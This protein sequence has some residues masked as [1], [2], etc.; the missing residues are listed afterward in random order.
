MEN[1]QKESINTKIWLE[2]SEADNPFAAKAA[3][4]HGY[5][6]Y[7]EMLGKATWADMIYLL[8]RGEPPTQQKAALLDALAVALANPGPRDQSVHAAMC[9]GVAGSTAAACLTAA[10]AVGAGHLSGAHEIVLAVEAWDL[11]G[12]DLEKWKAHIR[13]R[14]DETIS[15]WPAPQHPSGFDPHG[16]STT[17]IVIQTLV[18]LMKLS[19]GEKLPWLQV[20][21]EELELTAGLPLAMSAVA[22]AAFLD[23][24]FT[25]EQAE[26]LHLM[27]R[28]PGAAVHALEQWHYGHKKFPFFKLEIQ[29]EPS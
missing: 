17:T 6:V 22:A 23:L 14:P 20:N 29:N 12:T 4:C 11:C 28:L 25:K 24:G 26:M 5:D 3:Y 10:L 15:I 21:R 8:F 1:E 27:L 16:V 2:E 13:K 7:G 9:G 18:C 19:P